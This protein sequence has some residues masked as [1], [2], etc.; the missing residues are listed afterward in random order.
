MYLQ[1]DLLCFGTTILVQFMREMA[2]TLDIVSGLMSTDTINM[3][4][5]ATFV[6]RAGA[7][8][9]WVPHGNPKWLERIELLI[10]VQCKLRCCGCIADWANLFGETLANSWYFLLMGSGDRDTKLHGERLCN[11]NVLVYIWFAFRCSQHIRAPKATSQVSA[12]W[13][14]SPNIPYLCHRSFYHH[15]LQRPTDSTVSNFFF[16]V[17]FC[18]LRGCTRPERGMYIGLVTTMVG[19]QNMKLPNKIKN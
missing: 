8:Y 10:C 6:S 11:R 1:Q 3:N 17:F 7:F 9:V 19:P 5:Y 13:E 4:F 12:N 2:R 18:F 15:R 16:F 14:T